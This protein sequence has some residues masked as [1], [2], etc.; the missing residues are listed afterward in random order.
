MAQRHG[1]SSKGR[2]NQSHELPS[3][4][5]LRRVRS[6]R[7]RQSRSGGIDL[8]TGPFGNFLD[9]AAAHTEQ[10]TPQD[11]EELA[12]YI[13]VI[14]NFPVANPTAVFGELWRALRPVNRGNSREEALTVP[15]AGTRTELWVPEEFYIIG[16]VDSNRHPSYQSERDS[17]SLFQPYHLAPDMDAL[18]DVFDVETD[19]GQDPVPDEIEFQTQTVLAFERLNELISEA[20][21][22]GPQYELGHRILLDALPNT[23]SSA[24]MRPA[25]LNAWQYGVFPTLANYHETGLTGIESAFL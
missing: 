8:I 9:L 11:S 25:R 24:D 10:F 19:I 3:G 17:G 18:Q 13:P 20:D 16:L 4:D 7:L 1:A 2:T 5:Q 6:R 15:V 22:L 21:M 12:K 23:N 14:E